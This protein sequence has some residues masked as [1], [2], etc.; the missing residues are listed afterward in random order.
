MAKKLNKTAINFWLDAFLLCIFLALCWSSVVVRYVFPPAANSEG[1][2]LW[3][4]D[5]LAW[6]D[7]QF[8]TLCLMVAA[9][10]LHIMLHWTWVCGVIASWNRKRLGSTEKP[11]AD[12]GS[13]TLWG[14][15]LLILIVNV[16]G[17]AIAAAVLTIQGPI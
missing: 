4:G 16:L 6:T 8:V 10:L 9:V 11:Q 7:I 17:V 13:R 2:T 12:T 3:G 1:W 5:Y 14:V 15:G